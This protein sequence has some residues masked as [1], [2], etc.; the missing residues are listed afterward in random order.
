MDPCPPCNNHS[1]VHHPDAVSL[2]SQELYRL[3]LLAVCFLQVM[4]AS[5]VLGIGR[6]GGW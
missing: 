3:V 2:L 1:Q 5:L 6:E 4:A